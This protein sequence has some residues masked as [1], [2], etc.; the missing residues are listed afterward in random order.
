[1]PYVAGASV[2][3]VPL[4]IA[5][6]VQN[7]VLEA[8][9]ME[10]ATV[11]SP[12]ALEGLRTQPGEHLVCASFPQEWSNAVLDLFADPER[13]H[14]LGMEGRRYVVQ[15]HRWER[16]LE[17]FASILDLPVASVPEMARPEALVC[18]SPVNA[19]S[20]AVDIPTCLPEPC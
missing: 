5:R 3:V 10:R 14:R 12:Q 17:P 6:G 13:R 9:A 4:R 2:A 20:T 1:R 19:M 16:C 11:V 8:L 15:H 18:G 7:K